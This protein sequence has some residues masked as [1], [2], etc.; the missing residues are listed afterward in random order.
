MERQ[1]GISIEE[2]RDD[3]KLRY[4]LANELIKRKNFKHVTDIA[5]GVGYGSYLMSKSNIQKINAI[6]INKEAILKAKKY[7]Y[8]DKINFINKDIFKHKFE[9]TD[10]VVCYEFLEHTHR[11]ENL[12]EIISNITDTMLLSS[13]NE[14]VRPHLRQPVNPFHVK[15]WRPDELEFELRKYGFF[16]QNWFC[17][18]KSSSPI[19][20]GSNG[21]FMIAYCR[22][23]SR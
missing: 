6:E 23:L 9:K 11:H 18:L 10:L 22:K 16:V 12:F 4:I 8:S 14:N 13:P 19:T 1:E 5:C 15:H 2:I 20:Q 7:F 21:K 3:H 17:Q